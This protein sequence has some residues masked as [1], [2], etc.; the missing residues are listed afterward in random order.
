MAQETRHLGSACV[1]AAISMAERM[2]LSIPDLSPE[3]W[4]SKHPMTAVRM[5][6][7]F[8][9][10]L[11]PSLSQRLKS[12]VARI[13]A[14]KDEEDVKNILLLCSA[15]GVVQI[16][17]AAHNTTYRHSYVEWETVQGSQARVD[18]IS[19]TS[20]KV[21]LVQCAG[22]GSCERTEK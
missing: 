17:G 20:G 6:A 15:H 3:S 16:A 8:A 11:Q 22:V 4:K 7:P 18:P 21:P 14:E 12:G 13:K 1:V 9:A 10:I 19:Q 5:T 2:L